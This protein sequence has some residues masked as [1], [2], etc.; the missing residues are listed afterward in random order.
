MSSEPIEQVTAVP[1]PT[2]QKGRSKKKYAL[3]GCGGLLGL[4]VLLVIVIAL[5]SSGDDGD[6]Q[7]ASAPT[8]TERTANE[9][10]PSDTQQTSTES[11]DTESDATTATAETETTEIGDPTNAVNAT[12]TIAATS[13]PE[14]EP[15]PTT[16]PVGTGR[17]NPVPLGETGQAGDWEVQVLEVVRGDGAYNRLLEANQFNEPAPAGMEYVLV[18]VRVKYNGAESAAQTVD[19]SW[20][21][22]T[23]DARVKW[24]WASVVEPE[25][26]LDA[27]L[28][29]GAEAT[30]WT[31]V[32]ARQGEGNLVLIFEPIL[33]TDEGDE[34]F[35]ALQE[36]ASIPPLEERLAEEN[37]LGFDRMNPVPVGE[38]IVGET[39]EIWVLESVRGEE[40]LRRI[41][42][43]NQFNE[44]PA[45]GM[46]YVLVRVGARNVKP[47]SGSD[48]ISEFSFKMTGDAG[49][50][51]DLP[52]IVDPEP[53]IDNDVY[54]GG[55][56]D[57]WITLQVT[58]GEQN[59][60]LVYEPAFSFTAEPRFLA[61]Q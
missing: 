10:E 11:G 32:L 52:S 29:S 42:E 1:P 19:F 47:D 55:E 8:A 25:P 37:D 34:A 6:E 4:C 18:N 49:R 13:T 24:R 14:P 12:A 9:T 58:A 7:V 16:G 23:G 48:N 15:T 50:V 21:N 40:A 22:S 54:A 51:Y 20:F 41:K 30:G 60:R 5:V 3:I 56:V 26:E 33:S 57:G 59:L 2:E 45:P 61:I 27:E 44:D 53:T 35:L 39:W 43:A 31:T 36:N 28:F 46:E 38:R 17:S